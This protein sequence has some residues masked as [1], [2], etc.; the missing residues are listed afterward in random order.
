MSDTGYIVEKS[1]HFEAA[2]SLPDHPGKCKN[3]HGHSY[4]WK[5]RF[6]FPP[7]ATATADSGIL[8]DFGDIKTAADKF[9]HVHLNEVFPFKN[10]NDTKLPPTAENIAREL[11][12]VLSG[13]VTNQ[14]LERIEIELQEGI[15]GNVVYYAR[16]L[17]ERT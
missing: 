12:V 15:G 11:L 6:F 2:H 10:D 5:A 3:L 14:Y 13:I 16:T 1:G 17:K 7:T 8:V 9:D 4:A